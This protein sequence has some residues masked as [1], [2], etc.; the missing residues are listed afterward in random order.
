MNLTNEFQPIRDWAEERGLIQNG[1]LKTQFTKLGE[2]MGE[3]AQAILKRD[4]EKIEDAIG[5]CVVVLTN[6]AAMNGMKIERCIN[7]SF[8]EILNRKGK[9]EN[10][11]FVKEVSDNSDLFMNEEDF[12]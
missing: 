10:G 12:Q 1:D 4:N 9:M 2:E 7:S 11:T 5:D 8:G 3:L 6:F